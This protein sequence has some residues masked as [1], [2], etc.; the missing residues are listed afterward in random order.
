MCEIVNQLDM[1][2]LLVSHNVLSQTSNMGKTLRS[3]FSQ[4]AGEEIA[5]FYIH[6]EI[7]VDDSIC[8]NY[9]RFTDRDAM[10]SLIP[11]KK[12]GQSFTKEDIQT[13][14]LSAGTDTGILHSVYQMGRKRTASIFLLRNLLWELCRWDTKRFWDWV[15]GFS[16]DVIFFAS[17]DY[18]FMYDIARKI[19]DYT[20]KPL[21][22][23]CVDDFYLYNRNEKSLLGRLVHKSFMKTVH[24]TM[25]QASAVMTICDSMK[26]EYE[27]LFGKKT[28]VL[29]T[30]ALPENAEETRG[31]SGVVYLGNLGYG[32]NR[33]L[34]KMGQALRAVQG[35][36]IPEYIDVYS[37]ERN[38]K[39]WKDFTYEN[40]IRFHGAVSSEEVL[41]IMSRSVAV[42]HT[43]SFEPE[44]M[45]MT[46]FSVSTKIADSLMH[47]PCLV[48]Y[49]PEGIAS[50][51]YLKEN[52]AAYM[53]TDPAKLED[54]LREIL[55][56]EALR[57]EIVGKARKLGQKN[58]NAQAVPENV[59]RWLAE[60]C[61]ADIQ[62]RSL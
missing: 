21:I 51:D 26:M 40:G 46:R 37:G 9:F 34:V 7:P 58:H 27:K 1:K 22:V 50:V 32:R 35:A 60:I 3:Y 49:G 2:V 19:A 28:Y 12:C 25:E 57:N 31:R 39:K 16:P 30:A 48:A 56:N 44:I 42:I 17:G 55:S 6:S 41:A 33:Q 4:F 10:Q 61:E 14:C 62:E 59:K 13:D 15:D 11:W 45:K 53:I 18:G 24:R 38:P 23:S 8:R 36:G 47:G 5:Q 20:K 54:G 43:E 52:G 29:H